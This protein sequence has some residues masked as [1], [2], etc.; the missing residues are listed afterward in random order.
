MFQT[1][2]LFLQLFVVFP[3]FIS[4]TGNWMIIPVAIMI[5]FIIN[6]GIAIWASI[7]TKR[8]ALFGA[9][10]YF[11]FLRWLEIGIYLVAFAEVIVLGKFKTTIRGWA[12]DGRRYELNKLALSDV[13]K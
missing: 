7:V 4:V 1:V 5:D 8:W 11:Y 6:A 12:T 9:I 2:L 10:P 3:Y 13:A